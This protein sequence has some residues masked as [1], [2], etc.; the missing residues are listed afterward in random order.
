MQLFTTTI[1]ALSRSFV[2]LFA[3]VMERPNTD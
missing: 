2:E 3:V 1:M